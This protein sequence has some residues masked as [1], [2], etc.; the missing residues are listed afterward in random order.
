MANSDFPGCKAHCSDDD[1]KGKL[2]EEDF[3][4]NQSPQWIAIVKNS[5]QYFT[6]MVLCN[7]N[8]KKSSAS[9]RNVWY[10]ISE[11][12]NNSLQWFAANGCPGV[13]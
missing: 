8:E 1:K 6:M 7:N 9:A 10:G 4:Q 2:Q 12:V 3:V 13:P 11:I 5:S